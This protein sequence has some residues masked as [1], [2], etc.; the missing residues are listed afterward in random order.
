MVG[1]LTAGLVLAYLIALPPHL[2]HHLFDDAP[3]GLACS[4]LA[5]SQQTPELQSDPATL[6]PPTPTE[7]FHAVV[8]GSCLTL[9]DLSVSYPR[10]PPRF[11]PSA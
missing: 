2:V 3:G 7:S 4:Y 9:P 5:H 10:A 8:T 11:A 6:T 1:A